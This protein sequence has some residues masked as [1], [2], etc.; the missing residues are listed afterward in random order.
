MD[1]HTVLYEMQDN[2]LHNYN[3]DICTTCGDVR[4][5]NADKIIGQDEGGYYTDTGYVSDEVAREQGFK[6]PEYL[7]ER[8]DEIRKDD[9]EPE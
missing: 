2:C 1:K 4:V 5:D 6:D 9:S 8:A 3:D 7:Q